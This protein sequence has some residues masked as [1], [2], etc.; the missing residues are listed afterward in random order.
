M[1]EILPLSARDRDIL[2]VPASPCTS[3]VHRHT[4]ISVRLSAGSGKPCPGRAVVPRADR[5]SPTPSYVEAG[6]EM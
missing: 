2:R 3:D 5:Q 1:L 6:P 4:L